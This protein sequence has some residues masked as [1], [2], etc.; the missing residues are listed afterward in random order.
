MAGYFA[1]PTSRLMEESVKR[2]RNLLLAIMFVLSALGFSSATTRYIAQSAG[3][4]SG[5]TA[6]N[7]QTAITVATFN[8]TTL[9]A[10]DIAWVCG[11]I[12]LSAASNG[13]TPHN[14]GSS[15]NPVVINFDTGSS[16]KAPS[17]G[18][19]STNPTG[20]CI[21][22]TSQWVTVDGMGVGVV[23]NTLNGTSSSNLGAATCPGG[24]CTLNNPTAGVYVGASNV[25][26]KNLT[27]ADMFDRVPC[28]SNTNERNSFGIVI[29]DS[30]AN[31]ATNV[32]V[33]GNTIHDA[34]NGIP[35]IGGS[36]TQSNMTVT[37]NTLSH[38]SAGI[39]I[40]E[41]GGAG[42][43][44]NAV[45]SFND[46]SDA[47]YWWDTGD[48]DHL[49]GMH[50]FAAANGTSMNG[51]IINGNYIHGD[52]GGNSCGG[53]GSHT[54][55]MIYI[56][57]TGG[58]TASGV[59][60][61][62][63]VITT[64]LNDDPSD[65]MLGIGDGNDS[66]LQVY[67]NTFVANSTSGPGNAQCMLF[68]AASTTIENNVCVNA[69]YGVYLNGTGLSQISSSNYNDFYPSPSFRY[70]GTIVSFSGWQASGS[71]FDSNSITSDP[72]LTTSYTLNSGSPVIGLG[73]N[74]TSLRIAGL[75]TGA[76]Q[77]FGA[78]YAC[79]TGCMAR[80]SSGNWAS[81]GYPYGTGDA[82]PTNLSAV[83][84]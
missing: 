34:L 7:G 22:I 50:L 12:K 4:F 82:P 14:G 61:L 35:I 41:G 57:T 11:A 79:G 65:G 37:Q 52:F 43:E 81:G 17:C 3:T 8:S 38:M 72:K 16:I 49:N 64:G 27:V 60:V 15:G 55:S 46:I 45:I 53:G 21:N 40:A 83:V 9:S 33:Q 10:G 84:N 78:S 19:F 31:A 76:P 77:T 25:V 70:G 6:C 42:T 20:G 23:Q 30:A 5:G 29:D 56:E 80:S 69:L 36:G 13:I 48:S 67:N 28:N 24:T 62:N 51:L 2:S 71:K 44:S 63:N 74:L 54:T 1:N 59:K 32:T 18:T 68:T 66:G 39:V 58:G 75:N 73:A 47:Y 26:V